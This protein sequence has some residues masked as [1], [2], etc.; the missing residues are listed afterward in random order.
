MFK[1]FKALLWLRIRIYITNPQYLILLILPYVFLFLYNYFLGSEL[2]NK[3]ILFIILPL[4]FSMVLGQFITTLIAEEKEKNNLKELKLSN[5]SSISY[6]GSSL[7]LPL[8]FVII[9]IFVFPIILGEGM[10]S[11][12]YYLVSILTALTIALLYLVLALFVNTINQAQIISIPVMLLI[13]FLP[14][15]SPINDNIAKITTYT[16]M[17]GFVDIFS[18]SQEL[19]K[20]QSTGIIS[21]SIWLITLLLITVYVYRKKI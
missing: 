13:I 19:Y 2:S 17:G 4:L 10:I 9:N 21:L 20:F 14:M 8:L 6:I 3:Y 15:I 16:F 18:D 7:M 12:N 1:N 5:V 11:F